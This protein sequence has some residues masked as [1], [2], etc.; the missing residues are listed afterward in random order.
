MSISI[1]PLQPQDYTDWLPL[2]DG[3]NQG[4]HDPITTAKTWERLIDPNCDVNGLCYIKD[5]TLIGLVHYVLHLTTGAINPVCYMQDLYTHPDHRHTG[6]ATELIKALGYIAKAQD[7]TRVYWLAESNNE[8]AQ[9]L[10]KDIGS[11]L[12]FTLHVLPLNA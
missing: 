7:W 5:G 2:W 1:R 3:N 6:I 11:K 9:G 12:D 8:A 4:T 10:Y